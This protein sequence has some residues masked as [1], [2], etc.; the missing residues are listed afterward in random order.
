MFPMT[1][2]ALTVTTCYG[3]AHEDNDCG[4]NH[5]AAFDV[6]YICAP[7]CCA[8]SGLPQ[9]HFPTDHLFCIPAGMVNYHDPSVIVQD[10][11]PY[12]FAA[13]FCSVVK[14]H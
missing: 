11:R 12:T 8:T 1:Q 2:T 7:S 6:K 13:M 5:D 14:P 3:A 10:S 4:C 9:V